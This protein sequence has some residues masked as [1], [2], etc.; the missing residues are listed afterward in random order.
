MTPEQ[1]DQWAQGTQPPSESSVGS[2]A[3]TPTHVGNQ[4]TKKLFQTGKNRMACLL[5][6]TGAAW[7]TSKLSPHVSVCENSTLLTTL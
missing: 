6:G 3:G 2:V 5:L 7:R 1:P 4:K